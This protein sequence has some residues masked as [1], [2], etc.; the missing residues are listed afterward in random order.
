MD[1]GLLGL[2]NEMSLL[3]LVSGLASLML[4]FDLG[5]FKKG[6]FSEISQAFSTPLLILK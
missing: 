2:W 1:V 6:L 5:M 4:L 3:L